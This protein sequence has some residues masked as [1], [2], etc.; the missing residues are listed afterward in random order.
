MR[1]SRLTLLPFI[2][3]IAILIGLPLAFL[4][5]HLTT[6]FDGGRLLPDSFPITERGVRV[7]PPLPIP[8][9]FQAGDIVTAVEGRSIETWA[10]ALFTGDAPS[11]PWTTTANPRYTVLRDGREIELTI[12]PIHYPLWAILR[13]N[14]GL[15]VFGIIFVLIAGFVLSQR[16]QLLTARLLLLTAASVFSASTWS[17]GLQVSDFLD[18]RG[19]WLYQITTVLVYTL[20]WAAGLHFTLV[21]PRVLPVIEPRWRVYALYGLPYLFIALYMGIMYGRSAKVLAWIASWEPATLVIGLTLLVCTLIA[22][23]RQYR[24]SRYGTGR[25]QAK[26]VM[27]AG[28]VTGGLAL[29][30]YLLP[31]LLGVKPADTNAIG[32]IVALFPLA[33]AAAILRYRLFDIDV[34][35]RRTLVYTV[36]TGLLATVY[37]I[38]VISLQFLLTDRLRVGSNLAIVASTL[39]IAALFNPLRRRVQNV[40]DR[41]FYRQRYNAQQVLAT[42][43]AAAR[44]ETDPDRL[45]AEL[46]RVVNET[47]RPASISVWQIKQEKM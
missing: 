24:T 5:L 9:G 10:E 39:L 21:F 23:T 22:A 8:G 32:L 7:T 16:P 29:L 27:L 19:F 34:L 25:Q 30:F 18:G 26:W 46:L 11:P 15:I 40:I 38:S 35:I 43:A 2:L 20:Y 14:W 12:T 47:V 37:F 6:P 28:L 33:F 17:L 36:L 42:F 1:P 3:L 44:S 41:R 13:I 45:T 31:V 4:W